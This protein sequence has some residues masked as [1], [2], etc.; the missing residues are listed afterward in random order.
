MFVKLN[1]DGADSCR[2]L[3]EAVLPDP[4]AELARV[5]AA[6]ALSQATVS[7]GSGTFG[8]V[9][10]KPKTPFYSR[11]QLLALT[12]CSTA[13]IAPSAATLTRRRPVS[14]RLTLAGPQPGERCGPPGTVR[15]PAGKPAAISQGGDLSR[16]GPE[17]GAP[18]LGFWDRGDGVSGD[19]GQRGRG[20]VLSV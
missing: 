16:N 13:P 14:E 3:V 1:G 12:S 8:T 15:P 5:G 17:T 10:V 2:H 6:K 19:G 20:L 18:H 11:F 7:Y 9:L 4:Q